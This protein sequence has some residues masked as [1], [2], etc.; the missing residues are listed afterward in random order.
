M[1]EARAPGPAHRRGDDGRSVIVCVCV[2]GLEKGRAVACSTCR[3]LVDRGGGRYGFR[4]VED[5]VSMSRGGE[6]P[7]PL[8]LSN[9]FV[10]PLVSP[11]WTFSGRRPGC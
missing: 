1:T 6:E 10:P 8:L 9:R 2:Y 4:G 7:T 3:V 5:E 11:C